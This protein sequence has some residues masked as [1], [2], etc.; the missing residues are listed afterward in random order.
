LEQDLVS[1]ASRARTRDLFSTGRWWSVAAASPIRPGGV[2]R[3]SPWPPP[4]GVNSSCRQGVS[5]SCRPTVC[6]PPGASGIMRCRI[7][8]QC[9]A[10]PRS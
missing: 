8:Q 7:N 10:G 9:G 4:R 6:P 5:F 1:S 2:K 3:P